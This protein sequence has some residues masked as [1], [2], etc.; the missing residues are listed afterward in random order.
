MFPNAQ[1]E[2]A[3]QQW[4]DTATYEPP[5]NETITAGMYFLF[6][7]HLW[8]ARVLS[9][10]YWLL[11]G[12]ALFSLARRIAS[13]DGAIIALLYYLFLDF[14]IIASRSFQPDPLMVALILAG[15]WAFYNWLEKRTWKWVVITGL[16]SGMAIFVKNIAVF[17]LFG[18]F[19]L[20]ILHTQG[21]KS[22]IKDTQVWVLMLITALPT[23]IF[24]IFGIYIS[25]FLNIQYGLWF[26]PNLW[27][28]PAFY[29]RWKNILGN[30]LGFGAFLLALMGIYLAKPGKERSLL[31]GTLLGYLAYG[32]AFSYHVSTHNYYQLQLMVFISLSLAV[33]AKALF[34][35][36][37][38]INARSVF[39][40]LFVIRSH[41]LWRWLRNVERARGACQTRFSSRSPVLGGFG[42]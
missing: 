10:I 12:L 4:K 15:L 1:R 33:V 9:S 31:L 26:F 32:F 6:G 3:V 39:A 24:M 16:L 14:G 2:I 36:L 11:G 30:T 27:S 8:I 42:K 25:G 13:T 18:A 37:T 41:S 17:P 21:L 34:Q 20:S 35:R 22:A 7:E 40:R 28:D 38:E 29:I 5:L 23:A 19:A